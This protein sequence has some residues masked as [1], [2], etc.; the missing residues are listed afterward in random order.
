MRHLIQLH[1][2]PRTNAVPLTLR[3][4]RCRDQA[5]FETLSEP[6][7]LDIGVP[8]GGDTSLG[9]RRCPNPDCHLHVFVVYRRGDRK[10]VASYPAERI[11]FDA[12]KVPPRIVDALDEAITCH[13]AG[14]HAA[15]AML[16]RKTLEEL[17]A[18][19]KVK[20]RNLK[21]KVKKFQDLGI[22]PPDLFAGL[23]DLRLIGNDAA[24]VEARTYDEIGKEEVE[25]SIEFTKEVIKAIYQYAGLV[26]RMKALQNE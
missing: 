25:V 21:E 15:A 17:A 9:H 4:P 20:G 22:L 14:C 19:K 7:A 26:E 11:D 3:C 5:S 1:S 6:F 10:I 24:H 23:D 18:D 16:V 13:A 2:S 8:G 12:S